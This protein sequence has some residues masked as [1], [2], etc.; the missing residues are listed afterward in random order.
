MYYVIINFSTIF[1]TKNFKKISRKNSDL[2]CQKNIVK[3]IDN[4]LSELK[5]NY[6]HLHSY[7][8]EVK[9]SF[10]PYSPVNKAHYRAF[11]KGNFLEE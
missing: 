3:F 2:E 10:E 11:S 6:P 5:Q 7:P 1:S 8:I 9:Y 4:Q